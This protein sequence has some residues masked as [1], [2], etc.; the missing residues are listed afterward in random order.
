MKRALLVVLGSV[1]VALGVLGAFLP[2][3]PTTPFLLLAAAC[4]LHSSERLYRWL[5]DHRFLGGYLRAYQEGR[6]LS[7]RARLTTLG[8]L[9]VSTLSSVF[10]VIPDSPLWLRGL[11]LVITVLVSI[12]VWR[13]GRP[14]Q[15]PAIRKPV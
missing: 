5:L 11:L 9:W 2:V 6:G 1:F 14:R 12:H 10:L 13:L 15:T 8:V 7:L 3:L 4:Y